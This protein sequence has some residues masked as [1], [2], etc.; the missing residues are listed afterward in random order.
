[1]GSHRIVDLT[2]HKYGRLTVLSI[3]KPHE[4]GNAKWVCQCDCGTICII[5]GS[6]LR[7]K[8]SK[9]GTK[10]CGCKAS[11]RMASLN[12]TH[13]RSKTR[14]Y[15]SWQG[16]HQ[17][18]GNPKDTQFPRYGARGISVNPCWDDFE[19]FAL[20]AKANGYDAALEIDRIDV[21]AG[22]SPENCRWV[23]S[24]ENSNNRRNTRQAIFFG[25]SMVYS[26]A[27]EHF[28]ISID[29]LG[30]RLGSGWSPEKAVSTPVRKYSSQNVKRKS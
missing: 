13:G 21:N 2:G 22:Y 6:E 24:R 7:R 19:P 1:M 10:S 15:R 25:K 16:M 30:Y 27:A 28:G 18:C 29:V 3:V 20:W 11:E 26:E 17:R 8:A 14:L 5:V 4:G 9:R 12:Q 23:T